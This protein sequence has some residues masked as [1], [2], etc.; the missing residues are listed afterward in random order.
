MR[1]PAA[2]EAP[3][4][5]TICWVRISPGATTATPGGYGAIRS[6]EIHPMASRALTHSVSAK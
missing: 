5:S 3:K 2:R 4:P 6:A 1:T